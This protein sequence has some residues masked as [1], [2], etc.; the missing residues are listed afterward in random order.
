MKSIA[1]SIFWACLF[2]CCVRSA[3]NLDSDGDGIHDGDWTRTGHTKGSVVY[4]VTISEE[5]WRKAVV[6]CRLVTGD[7]L[8]LWMNNN[9]AP[10]VSNG[11]AFFVRNLTA[12]DSFGNAVPIKDFGQA[13]WKITPTV[14]E[15]ITLNYEVLLEHDKSDLP[16]GPDEA[17]YLTEDGVF[18]T[19]RAL[20]IIADT[21]G[22][23]VH[24]DLPKGW[25]VSTPW[26]SVPGQA[27]T[28]FLKNADEL[29]EAFVFAGTHI[30]EQVKV[31][32]TDILFAVGNK[33]KKSKGILQETAQKLLN[34]YVE[35][36]GGTV[37]GRTLIVVNH[38]D[39]K[40][41]FDGG[42][43]GRSVSMLIGDEPN[44]ENSERWA[45]LL[46]TKCFISGMGKPL[47]TRGRKIGSVRVLP[48]TTRWLCAH[49]W[50]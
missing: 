39:R 34:A 16:W 27:C 21:N 25:H 8:S 26:Q 49:V 47:N 4:K 33:F 13:R 15:S 32:D 19:G 20:F 17:P 12:V 5:N 35:M 1:F 2:V 42:V 31:G 40:G 50:V 24:L 18:W 36:F 7:A 43:F 3:E 45:L 41:S 9:G 48:T 30:E 10:R 6:S 22:I 44:E 23:T 29:T 46:P 28:F 37:T 11:Y 14:N 38:Q